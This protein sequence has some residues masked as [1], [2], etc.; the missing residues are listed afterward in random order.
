MQN[1]VENPLNTKNCECGCNEH[2][3]IVIDTIDWL[4]T[5]FERRCVS[6]NKLLGY[7]AYGY[8]QD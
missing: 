4:V 7:W 1:K 3:D 6:C 2:K 8:W 5:E